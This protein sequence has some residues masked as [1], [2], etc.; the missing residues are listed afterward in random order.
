MERHPNL[1]VVNSL[2]LCNG[3]ITRRRKCK[4][5]IEESVI[6]FFVVCHR[7]LPFVKKMVI[8][9]SKK[10]I[11]TNYHG[12]KSKG[13]AIDSDHFT[14][15][16]EL[17]LKFSSEKPERIEY[18]NFKDADSQEVFR[19]STSETEDFTKVFL[20]GAPLKHQ[21]ENW[22]KVL[23]LHCKKSFK[24]I[25]I[26]KKKI[27]PINSSIAYLINK[28]N[29]LSKDKFNIVTEEKIKCLD[30]EIANKEAEENRNLIIKN[31]KKFSDNPENINLNEM[32]KLS[33]SLWPKTKAI[34]P[35]AKRNHRGR[36][37]S[38]P[39]EIK[40]VLSKEYKHRLRSRP[41]RPDMK[42]L[43]KR[44]SLI[45][46]LKNKLSQ[47]SQTQDWTMKDME[48]ALS[49]LKNNKSRD[50]EGLKNEIFK[51]G[52]IG[53]N[54]KQ[55]LL[56]MMNKL[57]LNKM[58]PMFFN[59][60]DI[61]TVPKKGSVI[62]PKNERGIFGVS[63]IRAILMRLIYNMKYSTI[64]RNMSDCQM[65][66]RKK[67][68]CKNNI[69]IVNGIIHEVLK[70]KKNNPVVLQI[71]DYSQMFD[72]ID[73]EQAMSDIYD[74]GIND[75]TFALLHKANQEIHMAVKTPN[76]LTE[77]QVVKD[78]VLQGDTFGSILASVQVDS[79]GKECLKEN[80]SYMY[81]KVL[82]VGFL[83]L[84]DDIIGIT[85]A[86]MK[87]QMLNVFMNVKSAEKT[88]Q[89]GPTKC[90]SM[91]VGKNTEN[92]I[93]TELLVDNWTVGYTDNKV[94]GE[95][96]MVESYI[97]PVHMDSADEY[98]YLGF[99]IS[100]KGDN[101]ANIRQVKNKSIG[102]IRQIMNRLNSLNLRNYYFECAIIL[103]N[104]MLR[105]SILYASDMYYNLKENEVRQIERIE[106]SYLRKVLNTTKGCPITQLYL[107]MGQIPARFVIQKMRCLYLKYILIQEGD[108]LLKKFFDLQFKQRS[109]GDWA[110][111]CLD[112][113]RQLRI[114][115]S[116]EEIR[117]M[118]QNKYVKILNTRMNENALIYLLNKQKSK[119]K[120][121]RYSEMRMAEYLLPINTQLTVI[122]K[123]KM[124]AVKN[125]MIE[126][127]ENFP[128]KQL[129]KECICNEIESM[130]HIYNCET[131]NEGKSQILKF[132]QIYE[133]NIKDQIEVFKHFEENLNRRE[134]INLKPP[135]DPSVIRYYTS[136]G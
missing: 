11:L 129:K 100:S 111:T 64:D 48:K 71:Y 33:K 77:R 107:E 37:V 22:R 7:V 74:V 17:D 105:G 98:K 72:S 93:N 106:E 68:G 73:L 54:L 82:P 126:I 21:I 2:P 104:S 28:R 44:K 130:S 90:K 101:M 45:F 102:I 91:L 38:S 63:V 60:A 18:F 13:K 114:T 80:L 117:D 121:I 78:I 47:L 99:V 58:I 26:R 125:R 52:V 43:K 24:K 36:I 120:S 122:Q 132:E 9:E 118:N 69:F 56:I 65:G 61:T 134:L 5:L 119:G 95:D 20:D 97:G 133:G 79:I 89:F 57:K 3:L 110:S 112:D 113:L 49:D 96:D 124:F 51:N 35:S 103:M 27:K 1:T 15:Y 70:T 25:R 131:L 128:G 116:L 87:A 4:D 135:C 12:A 88:L 81:K 32:W 23:N 30:E 83:G 39:K 92:I 59:I 66:A 109:K 127:Y 29:I 34:L 86:G 108:S 115:E 42:S 8:D 85:E 50:F 94:T 136:N 10:F 76:G 62:E 16:V 55:S 41:V 14:E 123:Q 53:D 6:D 75:D 46:K 40:N 67:K 84:V 31:F 19:K